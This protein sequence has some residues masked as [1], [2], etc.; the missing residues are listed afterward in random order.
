MRASTRRPSICSGV[1]EPSQVA[2]RQPAHDDVQLAVALAG[3]VDRHDVR[4][5][6]GSGGPRLLLEALAEAGI[7]GQLGR[8]QLE[9]DAA[10]ERLLLGEI[11]DA[12]AAATDCPDDPAA[13]DDG[14][15]GR[16]L[17]HASGHANRGERAVAPDRS[18]PSAPVD[19]APVARHHC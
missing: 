3:V 2:A 16:V 13:G 4:M 5:V 9:R 1:Q 14:A 17:A 18:G 12:H 15:A 7:A 11:D 6:E 10:A 8:E 19:G